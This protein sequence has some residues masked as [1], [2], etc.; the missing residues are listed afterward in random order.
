MHHSRWSI[1]RAVGRGTTPPLALWPCCFWCSQGHRC[2]WAGIFGSC[3]ASC[4]PLPLQSQ[5]LFSGL[6]SLIHVWNWPDPGTEPCTWPCWTSRDLHRPSSQVCQDPS[7]WRAEVRAVLIQIQKGM[8]V[9]LCSYIYF[10]KYPN[11]CGGYD[12]A[13][14]P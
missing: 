5:S 1:R 10:K 2:F 7:G 3:W 14:C 13:S 4:Q 8:A 6:L 11:P 9:K 12:L